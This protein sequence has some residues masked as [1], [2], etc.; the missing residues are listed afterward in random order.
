MPFVEFV[1]WSARCVERLPIVSLVSFQPQRHHAERDDYEKTRRR[2]FGLAQARRWTHKT[3]VRTSPSRD[4]RRTRLFFLVD[5]A[6]AKDVVSL[7]I[8]SLANWAC[9]AP[10]LRRR[11]HWT[12]SRNGFILAVSLSPATDSRRSPAALQLSPSVSAP[13]HRRH[14]LAYGVR[15]R[16]RRDSPRAQPKHRQRRGQM[17]DRRTDSAEHTFWSRR[18]K[19]LP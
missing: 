5:R 1:E 9:P 12:W 8:G 4:G 14:A 18:R 19:E 15:L 7:A 11:R 3:F 16:W 10:I 13:E 2:E 17:T 6:V